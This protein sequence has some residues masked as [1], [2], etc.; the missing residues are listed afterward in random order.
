MLLILLVPLSC[1][2]RFAYLRITRHPTPRPEYWSAR[3]YSG[4]EVPDSAVSFE[5]ASRKLS[6]A[7][8]EGHATF[9]ALP[10]TWGGPLDSLIKEAW[11]ATRQDVIAATTFFQ[12][13]EFQESRAILL[14][15]AQSEWQ[16]NLQLSDT[17]QWPFWPYEWARCLVAH[18]RWSR[19]QSG[20]MAT[21]EEDLL[22]VFLLGRR[23]QEQQLTVLRLRADAIWALASDEISL[24]AL[25]PGSEPIST[26][27][28]ASVREI[29]A[30]SMSV[31]R[32]AE[33]WRLENLCCL[34]EIYVRP[35]GW[36]DVRALAS[37]YGPPVSPVWNLTSPIFHSLS[38]AQQCVDSLATLAA[39]CRCLKDVKAAE[40][41]LRFTNSEM[42]I[43]SGHVNMIG[44]L[45]ETYI[46]SADGGQHWLEH[47]FSTRTQIEAAL[48]M[49]ALCT[50]RESH[51]DYP[52][53]L[54]ELVPR[55]LDQM[56]IDYADL[57]PLR[58]RLDGDRYLLY[59]IGLNFSDDGGQTQPRSRWFDPRNPDVVFSLITRE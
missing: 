16:P 28:V 57:E 10:A 24:A 31:P 29:M 47:Y 35:G 22:A 55:F 18:A 17:L 44:N 41:R 59:S 14:A 12:S 43:L 45:G 1:F 3:I 37:D 5:E 30:G 9:A 58:Y 6:D 33:I 56:P 34:E 42:N 46:Y 21:M 54:D 2:T 25:E 15:L 20:D 23:I 48:A 53:R 7:P 19:M 39:Q 51:G 8:W 38:E 13:S 52:G 11:S 40:R 32:K 36:L 26:T 27:F 50:Y 49:A 4:F